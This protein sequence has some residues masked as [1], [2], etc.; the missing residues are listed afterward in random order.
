M[1]RALMFAAAAFCLPI[2]AQDQPA[3]RGSEPTLATPVVL[4]APYS[5]EEVAETISPPE[6]KPATTRVQLILRVYR[7]AQGHVRIESG[8]S[9]QIVDCLTH[10]GYRLDAQEHTALRYR[11]SCTEA[12]DDAATGDL[13]SLGAR[14]MQGIMVEG[15]LQRRVIVPASRPGDPSL[16]SFTETWYSPQLGIRLLRRTK[17]AFEGE[18]IERVQNLRL[19]EPD[20]ALFVVPGDYTIQDPPQPLQRK[21]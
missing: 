15:T 10:E 4:G 21:Q 14:T 2:W 12:Y 11:V 16:E 6:Y 13:E 9:V 17:T 5:A 8:N 19:G 1:R 3:I 7:D 20:R 18:R